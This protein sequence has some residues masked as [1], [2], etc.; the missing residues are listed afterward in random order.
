M[1]KMKKVG[2]RERPSWMKEKGAVE[3]CSILIPEQR[4]D[5]CGW[6]EAEK[7]DYEGAPLAT[8]PSQRMLNQ[9]NG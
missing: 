3:S 5:R 6:R 8:A 4:A 1:D 7:E 2:L 9:T